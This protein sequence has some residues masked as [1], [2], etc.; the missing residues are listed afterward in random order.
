[1]KKTITIILLAI[2]V[3]TFAQSNDSIRI[4][5]LEKQ[6]EALKKADNEI[7]EKNSDN[8]E[9]FADLKNDVIE[10]KEEHNNSWIEFINHWFIVVGTLFLL[11]LAYFGKKHFIENYREKIKDEVDKRVSTEVK[12]KV[13]LLKQQLEE[14]EKHKEYKTK[15]KIIV[16]NKTG[17]AFPDNFKTVL[18]LFNVDVDIPENR[19]DV[20]NLFEIINNTKLIEK[21]K[22]ADLV[23]VENKVPSNIWNTST[24]ES[25]YVNLANAICDTTPI[26]YYGDGRYP[27]NKVDEDKQHFV[28]YTNASSQLYGNMLNVL[29]YKFELQNA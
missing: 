6:V 22:Q 24:F 17:T 26:L 21:L 16:V 9:Q 29:K 5:K 25:D 4:N 13:G 10:Y 14:I 19:V 11:A 1:M 7:I 2:S 23:I 20:D 18:K 15:S 3:A 28:A 27:I 8:K 12:S